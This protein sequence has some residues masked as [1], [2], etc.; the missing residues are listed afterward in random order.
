MTYFLFNQYSSLLLIGVLQGL[1][2]A[3][4]LWRRAG[5]WDSPADRFAAL[6][7][8]VLC[9]YVSPW[10]L[11][12]AGW[13]D[14]HNWQTTVMFY[15]PWSNYLL[16][17][18]LVYFYFLALTNADFRWKRRYWW[19]FVPF[20]L[21]LLEPLVVFGY[22]IV[23]RYGLL[24]E[25]L[26][27]FFNTRGPLAEAM[28]MGDITLYDVVTYLFVR[29]HLI[30][31]LALTIR[32]YRRYRRYLVQYF[33][34]EDR[35]AFRWVQSLLYVFLV[36]ISFALIT[37]ILEQIFDFSYVGAWYSYFVL[38]TTIYIISIQFF[39]ATPAQ[40]R[41]LHFDPEYSLPEEVPAAAETPQA[42]DPEL[43]QW[44]RRLEQHMQTA[45]PYLD[46]DLNL[47]SLAEQ[48]G[49]NSSV[50]SRVV[51]TREGLN[52][53]DYVNGFRCREVIRRFE[54][55]DHE[56]LTFL[57]MALDAGFNSKA[58]FNRAFKKYTGKSP[59]AFVDGL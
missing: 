45:R 53:N 19:H 52:F 11:G 18:P 57:G 54:A 14:A 23:Y 58:T 34:S 51:N 3:G 48:I 28:N 7:L 47:G 8:L 40:L 22:D 33:A 55:G 37:N 24:G 25:E 46:P 21:L 56:N 2:F 16:I 15:V 10:M 1:V 20:F 42:H 31:Y 27:Y 39:L 41:N 5:R 35:Y 29:I 38:G 59:R 43:E 6:L 44:G 17:G 32:L 30:V 36:G 9:F 49:T 50:L 4:L 26:L 12:F 13:Y